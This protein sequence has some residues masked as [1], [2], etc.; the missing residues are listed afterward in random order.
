[1]R[2]VVDG[3]DELGRIGESRVVRVDLDHRE[4]RRKRPLDRQQ[5]A[6]LLLDEVADHALGLGAED[7][8]R[9]G[10][11]VPVR[12]TLEREQPDLRTVAMGNDELVLAGD[13]RER[14]RRNPDIGPLMPGGHRLAPLQEGV[15]AERDDDTH[16]SEPRCRRR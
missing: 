6:D 16:L 5:V 15:A 8:K 2:L 7:V 11:N 12:G 1:M 3:A 10:L 9:I 13:P 14:G 4:D